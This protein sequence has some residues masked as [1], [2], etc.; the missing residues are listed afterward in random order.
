MKQ[1]IFSIT[2]LSFYI[3]L[4]IITPSVLLAEE[5]T[6]I[7][8][9]GNCWTENLCQGS[10]VE[11]RQGTG[12][13]PCKGT[14]ITLEGKK[15][16]VGRCYTKPP[17]V[18]LG[19][20]IPGFSKCETDEKGEKRCYSRGIVGHISDFYQYFIGAIAIL[21]VVMIMWGGF[22]WLTAAGSAS[23]IG[24]AKTKITGALIGLVLALGAYLILNTINSNLVNL[25]EIEIEK[26]AA[27][28][29]GMATHECVIDGQKGIAFPM[30]DLSEN[31]KKGWVE[32]VEFA[33]L[34][35]IGK[36]LWDTG[37]K[38]L[39]NLVERKNTCKN[40]CGGK[41]IL[42]AAT[43][44]FE[45]QN[46]KIA[47]CV[48]AEK[49]DDW[50]GVWFC[51]KETSKAAGFK[52]KTEWPKC[53]E[54]KEKTK[55]CTGVFC[56]GLN[57][58]FIESPE[59]MACK[60]KIEIKYPN[61]SE[62][63]YVIKKAGHEVGSFLDCGKISRKKGIVFTERFIGIHCEEDRDCVIISQAG[64]KILDP[65]VDGNAIGSFNDARCF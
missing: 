40:F 27:R 10:E 14:T 38:K 20:S 23:Q 22:L 51:R 35:V 17:K 58:C 19:V 33:V 15:E 34:G 46:L 41:G 44:K 53:G 56:L 52:D 24:V 21:A 39:T 6:D 32:K 5:E 54:K 42:A 36:W 48:C 59:E 16:R 65:D 49:T 55:D 7:L 2:I 13:D 3:L 4:S 28:Y 1:L 63:E 25:K 9:K 8:E 57:G 26:I 11:F 62:E 12:D 30:G 31:Q 60:D 29:Q 47:C 18:Y 64:Y 45:S 37:W 43:Q 61:G 50:Q